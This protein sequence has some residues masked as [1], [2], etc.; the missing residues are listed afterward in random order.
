MQFSSRRRR[1]FSCLRV[2]VGFFNCLRVGVG[3]FFASA[4]DLSVGFASALD[5]PVVFAL[6]LDEFFRNEMSQHFSIFVPDR[7]LLI[8]SL[9]GG[10]LGIRGLKFIQGVRVARSAP[11]KPV[12]MFIY[13]YLLV[14]FINHYLYLYSPRTPKSSA[15]GRVANS[16]NMIFAE[17]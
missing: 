1:I 7:R 10:V 3:C 17:L 12:Y 9:L 8:K 16:A 14:L 2:G 15:N 6:A 13:F 11:R 4:L 5:F